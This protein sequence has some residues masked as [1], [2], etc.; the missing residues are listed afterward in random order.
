MGDIIELVVGKR[1]TDVRKPNATLVARANRKVCHDKFIKQRDAHCWKYYQK[2]YG[3]DYIL[4]NRTRLRQS[5]V[6]NLS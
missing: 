3:M 5:K 2:K 6:M 1:I 4:Q